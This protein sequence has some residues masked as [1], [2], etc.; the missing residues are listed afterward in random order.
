MAAK[1]TW[2]R[3]YSS[4]N[5]KAEIDKIYTSD[6]FFDF[7]RH[8]DKDP[9]PYE[10]Y[11]G[12]FDTVEAYLIGKR[13]YATHYSELREHSGIH[14]R[15]AGIAAR[16]LQNSLKQLSKSALAETLLHDNFGKHLQSQNGRGH[17]AYNSV[18]FRNGPSHPLEFLQELSN[19]FALAVNDI[20][21]LPEEDEE[22]ENRSARFHARHFA[23][24]F[25]EEHA[26]SLGKIAVHHALESAAVAFRPTW[27]QFSSEKYARGR[28]RHERGGYDSMAVFALYRIISKIDSTIKET[29]VGTAIENIRSQPKID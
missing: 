16:T 10:L 6:F 15:R 1:E 28:Y 25:N 18:V 13:E 17:D 21:P 12:V 11:K 19:A 23:N 4:N 26:T 27:E 22:A 8:F 24:E 9:H 29:L 2:E 7:V 20:K 3:L 5:V 14:L